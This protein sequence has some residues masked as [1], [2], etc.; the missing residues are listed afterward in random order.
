MQGVPRMKKAMSSKIAEILK[1][2]K[3]AKKAENEK[4]Q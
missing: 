1:D 3:I 4:K 2:A